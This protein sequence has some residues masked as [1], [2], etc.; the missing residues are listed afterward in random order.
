[1]IKSLISYY[2][3]LLCSLIGYD[4]FTQANQPKLA[5]FSPE[6]SE[7]IRNVSPINALAFQGDGALW[8][9]QNST[10]SATQ[11]IRSFDFS[12]GKLSIRQDKFKNE[13][14]KIPGVTKVSDL[15]LNLPNGI[16]VVNDAGI[17]GQILDYFLMPDGWVIVASEYSIKLYNQSGNYQK[18]FVGHSGEVRA[19]AVSSN[20]KYLASGNDDQTISLWKISETGTAPSLRQA[21]PESS[22]TKLFASLPM[23]SLTHHTSKQAWK[24]VIEFLK[25]NGDR[26]YEDIEEV[27]LNLGELVMQRVT[28]FMTDDHQ[29]ICWNPTGY[30]LGTE[31]SGNFVGWQ[32]AR[33]Q[34]KPADFYSL[35][36]YAEKLFRPEQIQK[37]FIQGRR[38]EEIL[39]EEGAP[40]FDIFKQ[41]SKESKQ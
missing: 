37:S 10:L 40:I 23:D 41:T 21:F 8:I 4:G 6:Y 11:V 30:Y 38:V 3:P 22:W 34:H 5:V 32:L 24:T 31:D 26:N 17:D 39:K 13:R 28:L 20:G 9:S 18:E 27:Y 1:M 35:Q 7:K 14:Q 33:D 2:F 19:A 12:T 15:I 29:W 16:S 36:Q 25:S